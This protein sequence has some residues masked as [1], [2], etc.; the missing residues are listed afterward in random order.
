MNFFCCSAKSHK[1]SH[2]PD[3]TKQEKKLISPKK[4]PQ[5]TSL[6]DTVFVAGKGWVLKSQIN[7]EKKN[8]VIT[9]TAKPRVE[10]NYDKEKENALDMLQELAKEERKMV[11]PLEKNLR[12]NLNHINHDYG[13]ELWENK[14]MNEVQI[15]RNALLAGDQAPLDE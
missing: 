1:K 4:L 12:N 13:K 8:E 3:D 11:V 7:Q 10:H 6:N 5:G 14:P 15:Y 9:I 2:K